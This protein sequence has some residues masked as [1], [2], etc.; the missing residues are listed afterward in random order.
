MHNMPPRNL[1]ELLG[2]PKDLLAHEKSPPVMKDITNLDNTSGEIERLKQREIYLTSQL[3]LK[4][5]ELALYYKHMASL[6]QRLDSSNDQLSHAQVQLNHA[7]SM[8]LENIRMVE[9]YKVQSNGLRKALLAAEEKNVRQFREF[10]QLQGIVE[11]MQAGKLLSFLHGDV[12][13]KDAFVIGGPSTAR[14]ATS[15]TTQHHIAPQVHP[16]LPVTSQQPVTP[17]AKLVRPSLPTPMKSAPALCK[18]PCTSSV[19]SMKHVLN[20]A[21]A[22]SYPGVASIAFSKVPKPDYGSNTLRISLQA[23]H[24]YGESCGQEIEPSQCR[25]RSH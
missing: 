7:S 2:Q 21:Y 18:W 20:P 9:H 19:I 10:V 17:L 4:E 5:A 8:S 3:D 11:G 13:P 12:M 1:Y 6:Q 14:L 23:N 16:I 24:L 15:S 25:L 22:N